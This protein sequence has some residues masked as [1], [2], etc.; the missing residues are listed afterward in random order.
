MKMGGAGL[1]QPVSVLGT[2]V[3]S[4]SNLLYHSSYRKYGQVSSK[5]PLL[6]GE[7][8]GDCPLLKDQSLQSLADL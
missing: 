6:Q 8:Q 1:W 4:E 5:I 3:G 7:G 2:A